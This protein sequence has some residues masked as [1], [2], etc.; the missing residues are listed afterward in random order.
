MISAYG[1]TLT[2]LLPIIIKYQTI[3]TGNLW[4]N[5]LHVNT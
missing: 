1:D 4:F 3:S 5:I 2:K